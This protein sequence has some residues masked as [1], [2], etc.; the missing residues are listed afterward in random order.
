MNNFIVRSL[1]GILFV[2]LVV[3]S[4]ILSPIS[5]V[6]VFAIVTCLAVFEFHK[7]TNLQETVDVNP[8]LASLGGVMLFVVSHLSVAQSSDFPLYVFYGLFV[9]VVIVSGLYLK[10][11]NPVHNWAYFLTG[12]IMIALPL[13]LINYVMY[14]DGYNPYIVLALFITIWV[15]DTGAY[16]TGVTFGKH[17]LFE[18]ISPKK[19]W[20]G[21]VGGAVFSLAS[22]FVISRFIP[23]L[24]LV[25]W[26][27]F[28]LLVVIAGTYGDLTESLLKRTLQVKDSGNIIPGHGGILDRFDSLLLAAPV[29][30]IYLSLILRS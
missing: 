12:Q 15:N 1:S 2:A 3:G 4:V 11:I 18:R 26:L 25:E 23:V 27:I 16:L 6:I 21:F 20:E 10:R 22:G 5:F 7:L 24:S 30:F 28:S 19:S 9:I 8:L 14:A 13:S 29:I 17:W